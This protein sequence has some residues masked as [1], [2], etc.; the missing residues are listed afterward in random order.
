[1]RHLMVV[2]MKR[3][4]R[5]K[6]FGMIA[7]CLLCLAAG[8][9]IGSSDS[10]LLSKND[11][12][13]AQSLRAPNVPDKVSFC[14]KEIDM[15]RY[16]RHEALDRELCFYTY[17]YATTMLIFKR[18]NR[19]FP[20]IEPILKAND[21]PDDF[22]YLAVVES[23]L[24]PRVV[25]SAQAAGFWQILEGTGKQYGLTIN[26]SVDERFDVRKS[27]VAACKYLKAFYNKC[28]DW[29][30][31]AASYNAG[32]GR[33]SGEL[34]KQDASTSFDLWLNSETQRYVYK[35]IAIKR[36]FESPSEFGFKIQPQD[37]YKPIACDEITVGDVPDLQTFA[38]D[39]GVTFADIK[40]FNPWLRD[41]SL[42]ANGKSYKILVPQKEALL[43]THPNTEIYNEDWMK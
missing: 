5:N 4:K 40:R 3:N 1:M 42:D 21:V 8:V 33:I 39:H 19:F 43:Y 34:D 32:M 23:T 10:I 15:R 27:T 22:K 9:F 30:T 12:L 37:L 29:A 7:A 26:E 31:V 35:I 25:S 17:N 20:I 6:H 16:D 11:S 18:A 41:R 14:G 13:K 28:G 38:V 24:D 36:V 2:L